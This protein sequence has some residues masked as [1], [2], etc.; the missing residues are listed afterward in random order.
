M[1]Y[2]S[3]LQFEVELLDH[4][5]P[6]GY[7]GSRLRGGYGDVLY[8]MCGEQA[9]LFRL[10][11]KP[12]RDLF[13]RPP[14]GP[15]LGGARELPP[16][17]VIDPPLESDERFPKNCRLSFGFVAFGETVN[18]L[19]DVI[20]AFARLGALGIENREQHARFRLLDVRDLLG[21]GRSL[22][23]NGL[24]GQPVVRDVARLVAGMLPLVTPEELLISFNT[25]VRIMRDKFPP[26][27]NLEATDSPRPLLQKDEGRVRRTASA[28]PKGIRDFYELVL[29]LADR[30][31]GLWQIYGREWIGKDEFRQWRDCLLQATRRVAL[32]HL[33]LEKKSY[34]R[35]SAQ[36][37]KYLPIEG[38]TG[39]MH[40]RGDFAPLIELLLIGELVHIGEATAYGFGQYSLCY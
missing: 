10:L 22:Y 28:M 1:F 32:L 14:V 39:S 38:F 30:V 26:L 2:L 31:G 34:L 11:F 4:H 25:P 29:V 12:H 18:R 19:Q 13:E 27:E 36:Q 8:E 9:D 24:I 17:F 7:W 5:A 16:P 35:Y 40:L 6:T 3:K 21:G 37:K 23:M 20:R 15:P 33:A